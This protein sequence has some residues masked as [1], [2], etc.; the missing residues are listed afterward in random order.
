M[1]SKLSQPA[2]GAKTFSMEVTPDRTKLEAA[3]ADGASCDP[4]RCWHFLEVAAI[5]HRWDPSGRHHVRVDAG[6]VKINYGGWRYVADTPMHV[7]RSLMLFDKKMYEEIRIRSYVLTFRRTTKIAPHTRERAAQID[8]ARKKRIA[9]GKP[10]RKYPSM[11][12]R[13]EG[14]SSIV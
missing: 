7:K 13:V 1:N 6:H 11:R 3:I 4:R 12:A 9:A 5:L 10:D 2:F 8:S 14:F